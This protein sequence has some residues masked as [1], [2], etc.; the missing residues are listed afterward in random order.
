MLRNIGQA[1]EGFGGVSPVPIRQ[2]KQ[3]S[4][5]IYG[6]IVCEVQ[7]PCW[8]PREAEQIDHLKARLHL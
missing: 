4:S 1:L 8:V 3:L 7:I 5:F 2:Y 6:S